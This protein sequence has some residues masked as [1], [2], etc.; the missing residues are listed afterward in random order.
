MNDHLYVIEVVDRIGTVKIGRTLHVHRRLGQIQ[1][2]CPDE[3]RLHG[4]ADERGALEP[5]AHTLFRSSRLHHE[6]FRL[7]EAGMGLLEGFVVGAGGVIYERFTDDDDFWAGFRDIGE[8]F[9][10]TP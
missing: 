2:A 3:L 5:Y 6:W 8:D 4:V 10:V 7:D 1:A 9:P